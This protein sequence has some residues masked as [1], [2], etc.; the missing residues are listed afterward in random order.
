MFNRSEA[1]S[2]CIGNQGELG[3]YPRGLELPVCGKKGRRWRDETQASGCSIFSLTN[4]VL[5]FSPFVLL[6]ESPS[7]LPTSS[8]FAHDSC[9]EVSSNQT[10][11][12]SLQMLFC[13]LP[14]DLADH[15]CMGIQ[16]IQ[17]MSSYWRRDVPS[18][19]NLVFLLF[20]FSAKRKKETTNWKN[21]RK[22]KPVS[23]CKRTRMCVCV[24]KRLC[25]FVTDANKKKELGFESLGSGRSQGAGIRCWPGFLLGPLAAWLNGKRKERGGELKWKLKKKKVSEEFAN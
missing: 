7:S 10:Q 17:L 15:Y 11:L 9:R 2:I 13:Q 23:V 5:F 12:L 6:P 19:E 21:N 24:I 8:P 25:L 1:E 20:A 16:P 14:K 3:S 22:K 18:I 4:D